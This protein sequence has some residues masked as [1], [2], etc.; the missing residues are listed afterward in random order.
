M[1]GSAKSLITELAFKILRLSFGG[2]HA[3]GTPND[4]IG[5]SCLNTTRLRSQ[6]IRSPY[7]CSDRLTMH[8]PSHLCFSSSLPPTT[9]RPAD[10]VSCRRAI[11]PFWCT[12]AEGV[13]KAVPKLRAV[14]CW[15]AGVGVSAGICGAEIV[16][17][18]P[19][20]L[21][22]FKGEGGGI[23]NRCDEWPAGDYTA[24][25]RGRT[26]RLGAYRVLEKQVWVMGFNLSD[27]SREKHGFWVGMDADVD[28]KLDEP[29]TG[30]R[31]PYWTS[32]GDVSVSN[33]SPFFF[34][35]LSHSARWTSVSC[36]NPAGTIIQFTDEIFQAQ[37][38]SHQAP[39]LRCHDG[40]C[41][42][43]LA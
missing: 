10:A 25:S 20:M 23:I 1:N 41:H 24:A 36:D 6:S 32:G 3:R 7:P 35:S 15:V 13:R 28:G 18:G 34:A 11:F 40:Q 27:R 29:K 22:G 19:G 21:L 14:D 16:P 2:K 42:E 30:C 4:R 33:F 17:L 39:V 31:W 5:L 12:V 26:L 8:L 43:H 37:G 9:S 38:P